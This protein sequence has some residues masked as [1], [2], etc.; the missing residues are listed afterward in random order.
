MYL[1]FRNLNLTLTK[2]LLSKSQKLYIFT[3][4]LS[5]ESFLHPTLFF[6]FFKLQLMHIVRGGGEGG[7]EPKRENH[8]I[9][10]TQGAVCPN[11]MSR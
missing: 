3:N 2:S 4:G 7:K 5:N 6:V 9:K 1:S 11:Y 8:R 10:P